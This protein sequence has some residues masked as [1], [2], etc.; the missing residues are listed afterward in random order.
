[1]YI[2]LNWY[3]YFDGND[4]SLKIN[5]THIIDDNDQKFIS[6]EFFGSLK[7]NKN[8]NIII[9]KTITRIRRKKLF[10]NNSW[11]VTIDNQKFLIKFDDI[12]HNR[13]YAYHSNI[14]NVNNVIKIYKK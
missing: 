14:E 5:Y 9:G 8:N 3:L 6:Y 10:K 4:N 13:F 1:M 12:S 11:I 2:I 7:R